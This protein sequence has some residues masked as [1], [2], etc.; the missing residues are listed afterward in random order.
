MQPCVQSRTVTVPT[1]SARGTTGNGATSTG[2]S[3]RFVGCSDQ[4]G[5]FLVPNEWA[6][7]SRHCAK[8]EWQVVTPVNDGE[9]QGGNYRRP[10]KA[11]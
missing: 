8:D 5:T 1:M 10:G 9:R 2:S 11:E 6:E 3:R 7:R 4:S